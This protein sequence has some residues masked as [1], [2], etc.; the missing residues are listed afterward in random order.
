MTGSMNIRLFMVTFSSWKRCSSLKEMIFSCGR[1]VPGQTRR[2]GGKLC[3][4]LLLQ[5]MRKESDRD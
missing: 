3:T 1:G 2:K 4:D 5:M